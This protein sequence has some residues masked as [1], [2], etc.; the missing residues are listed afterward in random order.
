MFGGGR[1]GIVLGAGV[2]VPLVD[3]VALRVQSS[4]FRHTEDIGAS[5]ENEN[6]I[7]VGVVFAP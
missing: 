3:H 7:G 2:D 5:Y 4:F 6:I 1:R